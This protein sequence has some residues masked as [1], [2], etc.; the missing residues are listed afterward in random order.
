MPDNQVARF[1]EELGRS[2]WATPSAFAA[3]QHSLIERL[4]R[5]AVAETDS[6]A[7]RL[8]P[9]LKR[10]GGVDLARWSEIP[11]LQRTDLQERQELFRAR[12]VPKGAGRVFDYSTSGSTGRPLQ[13][14]KNG[15][16]TNSSEAIWER[17]YDWADADRDLPLATIAID[18]NGSAPPPDGHFR[19]GWSYLGGTGAH[20]F[21]AIE[22]PVAVQ[23]AFLE[24]F[25][26]A[27]LKTYPTNAAALAEAA[28]GMAWEKGLR[29]IFT[30]SETLTEYHVEIIRTRLGVEVTDLYASEEAGQM[31]TRCPHSGMYHVAAEAALVE[32]LR[33]DGSDA[34]PG[35]TG[36]VVVTPFYNYAMPLIRYD[37]GDIAE[38]P[39]QPCGCGRTLPTIKRV[40]GRSRDMFLLP[41]GDRI[42]PRIPTG[43]FVEFVAGK[44]W[45]MVQ[46]AID[47]IEL[48]Y[49]EDKSGR[50][51]DPA[52]FARYVAEKFG[53]GVEG[54]LVR[55]P[56]LPRSPGGKYRE[57][58][59]LVS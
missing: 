50:T 59:S 33:D 39:E 2:Q 32:V 11:I 23:S 40:L 29:R 31:A 45:Q 8:A 21:L 41:S 47:R 7:A 57:C 18:R 36:R 58:I 38:L 34:G 19:P 12:N 13:F 55:M 53:P 51:N 15:L 17:A 14:L 43:K 52:G 24:R 28:S 26:P 16:L 27:Y 46:V 1:T 6:Y 48:R 56:E 49:V 20:G 54:S 22:A 30:F 9:I 35:E 3:L 25:R 44:Q 5:H 4:A 37:Q 42:W 10:G